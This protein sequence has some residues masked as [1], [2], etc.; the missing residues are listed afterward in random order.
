LLYSLPV[1]FSAA[2]EKIDRLNR[3]LSETNQDYGEFLEHI[4]STWCFRSIEQLSDKCIITLVDL[5][6]SGERNLTPGDFSKLKVRTLFNSDISS[7]SEAAPDTLIDAFS[8]ENSQCQVSLEWLPNDSIED[9]PKYV[10][11]YTNGSNIISQIAYDYSDFAFIYP[12]CTEKYFGEELKFLSDQKNIN[13]YKTKVVK[14]ISFLDERSCEIIYGAASNGSNVSVVMGSSHL[15]SAVLLLRKMSKESVKGVFHVSAMEISDDLAVNAGLSDIYSVKDTGAIILSPS[16]L[17]EC[18]DFAIISHLLAEILAKPILLA[19]DGTLISRQKNNINIAEKIARRSIKDFIMG[20]S[21]VGSPLPI[22]CRVLQL[23]SKLSGRDVK[24]FHYIGSSS[25]KLVLICTGI[26]SSMIEQAVN[27]LDGHHVGLLKVGLLHPLPIEILSSAL[28]HTTERIIVVEGEKQ[29]IFGDMKKSIKFESC[30][31]EHSNFEPGLENI[32]PNAILKWL[33]DLLKGNILSSISLSG[34]YSVDLSENLTQAIFWNFKSSM[35]SSCATETLESDCIKVGTI[36]QCFD[37][38]SGTDAIPIKV[39]YMRFSTSSIRSTH[40]ID[41]ADI[42]MCSEFQIA[43]SYNIAACLRFRGRLFVNSSLSDVEL[44]DRLPEIVKECVILK[45]IE[46][47]SLDADLFARNFTIFYGKFSDYLSE[48]IIAVFYKLAFQEITAEKLISAQLQRINSSKDEE[49]VKYTKKECI[50]ESLAA[51]QYLRGKKGNALS[52]P[53]PLPRYP[54]GTITSSAV[55]SEKESGSDVQFRQIANDLALLPLIFPSK[56]SISQKLRPDVMNA[57]SVTVTENRRLTPDDYDRNVFHLELDISGTGLKYDIGDALGVYAENDKKKVN[58]FL[59]EYGLDGDKII[60][61]DRRDESG[62]L[63]SEIKSISQIFEQ[64]LDIFG[65]PGKKFYQ[66]LAFKCTSNQEKEEIA[67][68]L[69]SNESFERFVKDYTPTFAELLVR[70]KSAKFSS[71]ELFQNIPA[72]K[73][74]HYSIASSQRVHPNSVHL[75]V[76]VVDWITKNNIRKFGQATGYLVNSKIGDRITV[77]VKPSVMKLPDSLEA[78]VIMAGLGT[79]MAPFRAFI[80]ERWYWKQQGKPIG[81]MILYFGSRNRLNEYLYGEELDAYHIDGVLS[82]LR[83]AFSRDQKEK[84]YIQHKILEDASI[85]H[86]SLVNQNGAFYLCG[87]TWPVPDVTDALL[88]SF[89]L[90]MSEEDTLA[91]LELLKNANRFILEV[92]R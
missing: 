48:I 10:E 50:K 13:G 20:E 82:H 81:D 61:I 1:Q 67:L 87:P 69:E 62:M 5:F 80:E 59:Q 83:L 19:T 28:P 51:I 2:V 33:S 16:N 24:P 34:E 66:N 37:H 15:Q 84:V 85:L 44:W 56:Y 77:T 11:T 72:I 90:S 47:I 58:E 79:G 55:L 12:E 29:L 71:A 52:P 40:L 86:E 41:Q 38:F 25:A 49:N 9:G 91:Y 76:V 63:F 31:I 7:L 75:L 60:S 26:A 23:Y 46:L 18:H 6:L 74:R 65:R 43:Q 4:A 17:Q 3:L 42:V 32:S 8:E 14:S 53:A 57:F 39:S 70:F 73:P 64:I 22:I 78:P 92:N 21:F 35:L 36:L 30:A 68:I 89:K 45:E 88:D 27:V 54:T